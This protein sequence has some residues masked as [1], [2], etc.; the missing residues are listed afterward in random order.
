MIKK[1]NMYD[2]MIIGLR[3]VSFAKRFRKQYKKNIFTSSE[4]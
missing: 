1:H 3:D 2:N 4:Q